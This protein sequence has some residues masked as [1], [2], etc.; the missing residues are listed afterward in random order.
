MIAE[1]HAHQ[2]DP[3]KLASYDAA[4]PPIELRLE[5][6]DPLLNFRFAPRVADTIDIHGLDRLPGAHAV[7]DASFRRAHRTV[8]ITNVMRQAPDYSPWSAAAAIPSLVL[9]L[10]GKRRAAVAALALPF[11][12]GVSVDSESAKALLEQCYGQPPAEVAP[13]QIEIN[14]RSLVS[15]MQQWN[16]TIFPDGQTLVS[17]FEVGFV[18]PEFALSQN[19]K[20]DA[21]IPQPGSVRLA[22]VGDKQFFLFVDAKGNV[23]DSAYLSYDTEEI[24]PDRIGFHLWKP[25]N[26]NYGYVNFNTS[27]NTT[28]PMAELEYRDNLVPLNN[29]SPQAFVN[30]VV[31]LQ[32][33]PVVS[34][35]PEKQR[36]F[37][38]YFVQIATGA[39]PAFAA[40]EATVI[41]SVPATHVAENP[42]IESSSILPTEIP[43]PR[44]IPTETGPKEGDTKEI[45]GLPYTYTVIRSPETNEVLHTG[46]FRV[47]AVDMP[48]YPWQTWVSDGKG[49]YEHGKDVAPTTLL[50][51]E[52]VD[53]EGVLTKLSHQ[54]MEKGV[55]AT[56]HYIINLVDM[57]HD[58]YKNKFGEYDGALYGRSVQ[59]GEFDV[60]FT[61]GEKELVW[62]PD[63][64]TGATIYV[65]AYDPAK[66]TSEDG[67]V[68]WVDKGWGT[69]FWTAYWGINNKGIVGAMALDKPL[70][71]LTQDELR[72]LPLYHELA[73]ILS[74]RN[75]M[76][77]QDV[78]FHSDIER[79]I[80]FA[81]QDNPPIIQINQ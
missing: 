53:D 1:R 36:E 63:P 28:L 64:D 21:P 34:S 7:Y 48:I 46:F 52:G 24:S 44:A 50:V 79:I 49:G 6:N 15:E 70:S 69:N 58:I 76:N 72:I 27:G 5:A 14:Q 57:M 30:Q 26:S 2:F 61:D 31:D 25:D 12:L 41:A 9:A 22:W 78:K 37:M 20:F 8:E 10:A 74:A 68:K 3:R 54:T 66:I 11:S 38:D 16:N 17:P 42:E 75:G 67:F 39:K 56:S 47:I 19:P 4:R 29:T 35:S 77:V 32:F 73:A 65:L 55:R 18:K 59:N 80:S 62:A 33:G 71:E 45:N 23:T 43:L 40:S 51:E 81:G 13:A 60:T